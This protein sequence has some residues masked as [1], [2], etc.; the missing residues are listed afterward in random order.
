MADLK[1]YIFV[2]LVA[3]TGS[4]IAFQGWKS[5]IPDFDLLPYIDDAR[6]FASL[7]RIPK[8]GILTSF[9]SYT[10]P[11][12]AWLIR[13]GTYLLRDPRLFEFIVSATLYT[14]DTNL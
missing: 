10:P 3:T 4:L 2:L 14:A 8:K 7:G 12:T 6:Q 13:P 11:G 9:A 1:P 5:K